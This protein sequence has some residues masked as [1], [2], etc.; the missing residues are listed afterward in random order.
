MTKLSWFYK[1]REERSRWLVER[2]I[3]SFKNSESV[4]DVGCHERDL[5]KFIPENI[6]KYIGI[7]IGGTPDI[8]INL[9]QVD[10]LPF[11]NNEFDI[12]VCSDVLEHLEHIHLVFDELCRVANKYII[13]TLPNSMAQYPGIIKGTIYTD[14]PDRKKAFGKYMKFYGLPLEIPEDRHRWYFNYEE[15]KDFVKYRAEKNNLRLKELDSEWPY[16]PLGIKKLLLSFFKRINN[17]FVNQNFI[18]LLEK[19]SLSGQ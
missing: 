9:D 13:I 8:N 12:I 5:K 11:E 6:K 17:N 15:A 19:S 10:H 4:L 7:D 2:F 3:C 18:C 16:M 1:N 14:N